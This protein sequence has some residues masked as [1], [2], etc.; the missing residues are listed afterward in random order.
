MTDPQID[1]FKL[2][3]V[4]EQI[5][6]GIGKLQEESSAASPEF[7]I[8]MNNYLTKANESERNQA[9]LEESMER[10]SLKDKE[11][12]QAQDEK[13]ELKERLE[14][15]QKASDLNKKQHEKELAG[16]REEITSLKAEQKTI[17]SEVKNQFQDE[18]RATGENLNKQIN[19]YRNQLSEIQIERDQQIKELDAYKKESESLKKELADVQNKVLEEQSQIREEILS[20]TQKSSTLEDQYQEERNNLTSRLQEAE[21]ELDEIKTDYQLKARELEYKNALLDQALKRPNPIMTAEEAQAKQAEIE[22]QVQQDIQAQQ[23]QQFV[24]QEPQPQVQPQ[25]VEQQQPQKNKKKV[26]GIWSKLGA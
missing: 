10:M 23:Q 24:S 26:G 1:P 12:K 20:M 8:L 22:H 13:E 17:E 5:L 2:N 3:D 11:V 21:K 18:I 14:S 6:E 16:L 4:L 19:Y 25:Q 9:R 15:F 7:Q